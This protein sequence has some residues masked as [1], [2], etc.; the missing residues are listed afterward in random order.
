MEDLLDRKIEVILDETDSTDYRLYITANEWLNTALNRRDRFFKEPQPYVPNFRIAV[1]ESLRGRGYKENRV[2]AKPLHYQNLMIYMANHPKAVVSREGL[3][4]DD[5]M[6]MEQWSRRDQGDTIICSRDKDLKQVP[7]WTYTWEMAKQ[8]GFGPYLV[9]D[10][11][12]LKKEVKRDK[13]GKVK[14]TKVT[15][16]GNKFLYYQMI[17]GDAVDNISGLKRK[18]PVAS[19]DTLHDA[20]TVRECYERTAKLFRNEFEGDW[21]TAMSKV[22]S[23]VYLIREKDKA[24]KFRGWRPPPEDE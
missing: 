19:Y 17:A 9:D 4:A 1:A 2:A 22:A 12:W 15:G 5:L 24:G 11:G 23:L 20:T 6:A 18:G 14:E 10:L 16:V 21:K 8:P 3:E 13:D 7:G